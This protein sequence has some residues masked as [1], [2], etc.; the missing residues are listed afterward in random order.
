MAAVASLERPRSGA[1]VEVAPGVLWARL[2]LP[3]ALD[4][5]N[6][7]LLAD[8]DGWTLVDTGQDD[9]ATRAAWDRLAANVL[10][11]RPIRR[12][13]STH[14]HPDHLGL[15]GWMARRFGAELWT[16]RGE[17]LYGR[18][19]SLRG[20]RETRAVTREY[21]RRAGITE[22]LDEL[23]E[24]CRSYPDSVQVPPSF[25]RIRAGEEIGV[26]GVRWRVLVGGGH[27]PEHACLLAP[28]RGLLISGDQV[29]P[30]IT[31][32]VSVWP[33]APEED[34]LRDF[35]ATL[36]EL[37]AVPGNPLVLPSHG[38]PF[39]GLGGRCDEL[40]LHHHARLEAVLAACGRPRTAFE[41]MQVLFDRP[42][43]PH[44]TSFAIGEAIAHL[45]HLAA[46]GRVRRERSARGADR[47]TRGVREVSAPPPAR[48]PVRRRCTSRRARGAGGGDPGS[49]RAS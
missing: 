23:V 21:C 34:P 10:R 20:L 1:A 24:C 5:V 43:D 14:H 37:R 35:L 4:H 30:H 27:S 9:G 18:A 13:I 16:T 26:G 49:G 22:G 41:V 25:R 2:P 29:L 32:N 33:E 6:V 42:L 39:V 12:V 44:Q 46:E 38:R 40:A 11:G 3:Y 48:S 47:W 19:S 31:P 28:E 8:G 36:D 7:W 17:W 15:T 45:N